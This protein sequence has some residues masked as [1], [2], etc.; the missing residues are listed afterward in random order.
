M[1]IPARPD[2]K[3]ADP[4]RPDATPEPGS[5]LDF[6]PDGWTG[7]GPGPSFLHFSEGRARLA[8]SPTG[9]YMFGPG[10]GPENR[11]DGWAGPGRA[12]A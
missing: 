6:E 7:P 2:S 1:G 4:A 8:R 12:R 5:G 9:F 11:P 3:N 10:L